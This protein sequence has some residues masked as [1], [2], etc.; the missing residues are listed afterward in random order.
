VFKIARIFVEAGFLEKSH[1]DKMVKE[2]GKGLGQILTSEISGGTLKDLFTYEIPLPFTK[3]KSNRVANELARELR[4]SASELGAIFHLFPKR[5]LEVARILESDGLLSKESANKIREGV[6]GGVEEFLDTVANEKLITV[7]MLAEHVT[8]DNALSRNNRIRQ[9][10]EILVYNHLIPAERSQE[11]LKAHAKDGKRPLHALLNDIAG[12]D[13]SQLL[14]AVKSGLYLPKINLSATEI[15]AKT[16]ERLPADFLRRHLILPFLIHDGIVDVAMSD[17][18]DTPLIDVLTLLTGLTITPH[19][20]SQR[21]LILRL[22]QVFTTEQQPDWDV[23][24]AEAGGVESVSQGPAHETEARAAVPL[25]EVESD[26]IID[27]VSTVQLVSTIIE[28][29]IATEATDIH[30]EPGQDR[31]RVRYRIDGRLKQI[32]Q[33][34]RTMLLPLVSRIKVLSD[35]NVTERRRPQDGHLSLNLGDEAIDLRISI[36]PTHMGEKVVI[37]VLSESNVLRG[38][39]DLG[40]PKVE[41][42]RINHLIRRPHGMLLVSGPTGSGKT[43]TLYACLTILNSEDT[44]IVTIEDPVEYRVEGINQVQIDPKIDLT[45]AKGLRATLRQDPDVILVG[46]IRDTETARIAVRAALTGHLMLSTVHANSSA[47][48]IGALLHMDIP[49]Y[50]V[51]N[52]LAGVVSQRLVRKLCKSCRAEVEPSEAL[53]ND[54]KLERGEKN[55][56]FEAKGCEKCLDT[57]HQGRVGLYEVWEVT[58]EMREIILSNGGEAQLEAAARNAKIRSIMQNAHDLLRKGITS[59]DEVLRTVA[60]D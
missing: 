59:P 32:M 50:S 27:N 16:L 44:N 31:V 2:T 10:G 45:F 9:S 34:P 53:I 15:D 3:S 40:M 46:E 22:N 21:D 49:A 29:A 1:F 8:R 48:V 5:L 4:I 23:T 54:L 39:E 24:G 30:I 41:T 13:Q 20:A 25:E 33:V 17:P 36:L 38:L 60:L 26:E 37:R 42:E 55:R 52:S 51:A 18:L 57:G 11:I 47:G 58:P 12:F 19:F 6:A 14:R 7:E 43:T 56:L 28:S 35:L